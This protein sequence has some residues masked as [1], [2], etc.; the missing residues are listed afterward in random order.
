[1]V[2]DARPTAPDDIAQYI[3]D[4]LNR[5]GA[6]SLRQIAAYAEALADWKEAQAADEIEDEEIVRED[7]ED[8]PD[9]PDD[10]PAKAYVVVKEINNN[11]YYYYQWRSGDQVKSKYK[12]PVKEDQ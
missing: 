10:V 8:D 12:A 5:Q 2:E 7:S 4:G 11:R 1:M 6:E 9:R 3:V